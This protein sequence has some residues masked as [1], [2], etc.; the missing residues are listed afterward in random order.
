[1]AP[2]GVCPSSQLASYAAGRAR[3]RLCGDVAV[4]HCCTP[5]SSRAGSIP[6]AAAMQIALVQVGPVGVEVKA[7]AGGCME[8]AVLDGVILD[9]EVRGVGDPV[10]LIHLAPYADSCR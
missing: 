8:G 10:V 7:R 3:W 6:Y 1:V 2:L 5:A 9:Y 4:L